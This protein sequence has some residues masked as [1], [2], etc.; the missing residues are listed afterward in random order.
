MKKVFIDKSLLSLH[1]PES[2]NL[3]RSLI[4]LEQNGFD[5]STNAVKKDMDQ[6]INKIME[7]E[8]LDVFFGKEI[9][10]NYDYSISTNKS[11]KTSNDEFVV[12]KNS[13]YKTIFDAVYRI[14]D[15][16]RRVRHNRKT[17]ETDI[18]IELNLNGTGKSK[19]KT[20]VGFFDHM[21]DQISRHGNVDLTIKVNGDLHVDE[22]HTVEDTGIA[23]GEAI[24]KALGEKKG[25]KRYGFFL[26]MDETI[27]ECALDIGGRPY[28]NFKCKFER[29]MVGDFPTELTREFFKGLSMGM[30]ANI[31]LRSKGEN[32][33]HKIEAMFKAFARSLN[34]ACRIDERSHGNLPTT[35]GKI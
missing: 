29:E 10:D 33:H 27:A 18:G 1:K 30:N 34:E 2:K 19:I 13:K 21:L 24:T 32:D 8:E 9:D 11:K 26:P 25:I 7:R 23:L 14:C 16:S 31:Y 6:S 12:S 28:L 17:K 22:H 15:T 35:K 4:I 5:I 3:I 20:G